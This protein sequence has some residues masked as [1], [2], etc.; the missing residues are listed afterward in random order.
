MGDK[1]AWIELTLLPRA[2]PV[3]NF[4]IPTRTISASN[5]R[6][7]GKEGLEPSKPYGG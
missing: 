7:V 3:D 1:P 6:L 5:Y 4:Q 2:E